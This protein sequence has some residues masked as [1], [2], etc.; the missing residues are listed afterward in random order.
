MR[1]IA[2]MAVTAVVLGGCLPSPRQPA[3]S[4]QG[5]PVVRGYVDGVVSV[6]STGSLPSMP[7]PKF[8]ANLATRANE[9]ELAVIW[10]GH[11]LHEQHPSLNPRELAEMLVRD[12]VWEQHAR[13]VEPARRTVVIR[14][15]LTS[16]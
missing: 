1:C 7:W 14:E 13:F 9:A 16:W 3:A 11:E 4:V 10:R 12:R 15:A 6:E 5:S 8:Q 2:G